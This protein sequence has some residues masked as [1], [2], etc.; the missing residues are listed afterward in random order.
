MALSSKRPCPCCGATKHRPTAHREQGWV[1][2]ACDACGHVYM[3]V[4]PSLEAVGTEFEWSKSFGLEAKRRRERSPILS[5]I[6]QKTRIRT[7]IFGKKNP[8]QF[9]RKEMSHGHIID[10]GCGGGGYLAEAGQGYTLYGIDLSP[11]LAEQAHDV[12]A[13]S[14]GRAVC[15]SCAEGLNAF[16]DASFDAAILR[17]YLE[18]EPQAF[19]VLRNL[20][21]KLKPGGI[22]VIKV[23]NYDS[24]NRLVRGEKWCGFRYPDH[25]NYFTPKTLRILAKRCGYGFEQGPFDRLPFDDNFWAVLRRP[26]TA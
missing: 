25:V 2:V 14:G 19:E 9:V 15:D 4:V 7:R 11:V 21:A 24:L 1:L 6:D 20:F 23:P 22:A 18:H 26:L 17:S 5:W 8:M 12:F 16:P 10:L 3:P 13:R